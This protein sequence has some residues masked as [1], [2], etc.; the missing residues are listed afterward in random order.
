MPALKNQERSRIKPVRNNAFAE[1]KLTEKR[2]RM[3][4]ERGPLSHCTLEPPPLR[5]FFCVLGPFSLHLY[6]STTSIKN[7]HILLTKL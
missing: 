6:Y 3:P 7:Q 4:K 2:A 5:S 1:G